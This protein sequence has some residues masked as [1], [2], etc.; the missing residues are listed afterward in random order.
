MKEAHMANNEQSLQNLLGLESVVVETIKFG[1]FLKRL[2]DNPEIADT[3]AATL[4]RAIESKEEVEIKTAPEALRPYLSMLKKMGVPSWNAFKKVKGS[5]RTVARIMNNLRAAAANGYQLRLAYLLKGGPGSGKSLLADAFKECLEGQVVYAIKDCPV[6]ENPVNL[7]NLLPEERIDT[8]AQMLGLTAEQRL[9][10]ASSGPKG[11]KPKPSLRDLLAISGST[12]QV[13]WSEVME[14]VKEG[15]KPNLLNVEIQAMRLSSRKF[16]IATWSKD[17]TLATALRKGSRGVVDMPEIFGSAAAGGNQ[18]G[19]AD[20]LDLLLEATNDRRIPAGC[21]SEEAGHQCTHD[22]GTGHDGHDHKKVKVSRSGFEPLDCVMIGQTNDGAYDRFIKEQADPNKFTRRLQIINVPYVMSVSSEESEYAEFIGSMRDK[23]HFDP[24]TLKIAAL[25]AVISRMKKEQEVDIVSR[26]RMYDGEQLVVEMKNPTGGASGSD[27]FGRGLGTGPYGTAAPERK[28]VRYWSVGQ[29]WAEA[30]EDEGMYGLNMPSM[31]KLMSE[32]VELALRAQGAP[33]ATSPNAGKNASGASA[34]NG[35]K[36]ISTLEMLQFLRARIAMLQKTPGLTDKEKDVLKTCLEYLKAPTSIESKAGLIEEEY[37]R[38][39]RRQFLEVMAPDF[40]RR[41]SEIF[42]RYR[43]HARA[44]ASGEKKC[45][46][47]VEQGGKKVERL[48]DVSTDF[49]NDIE[50]WMKITGLTDREIFRRSVETQITP[51]LLAAVELKESQDGEEN[52]GEEKI[53][54]SWR[55]LPKLADGIRA[56]L[57]D[58]TSKK[59]GRL[60]KSEIDLNDEDKTLRREALERFS[61]L[62]YC[63]HCRQVALTYFNDYQLWKLS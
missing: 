40:D 53:E 10:Q 28:E 34:G 55:S 2:K 36:C 45:K 39:L 20:E 37:R 22:H 21:S 50:G 1:E 3:A 61:Q 12:C 54:L 57:N 32:A 47:I 44:F 25:L 48:V 5:Q 13:C 35:E 11:V 58:E 14:G 19:S 16:G 31:L 33:A 62:G 27:G 7:L 38:V 26:A 41:A 9:E 18:S 17:C 63:E 4:V 59:L 15:D 60:L 52:T 24:M 23:P 6:N 43:I 46:E 30:G 8:I 42:E 49:L 29:F 56:K 51:Y